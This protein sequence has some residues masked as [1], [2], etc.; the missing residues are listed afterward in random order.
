[1]RP[2]LV[3]SVWRV[4]QEG[5][6]IWWLTQVN[7]NT[8]TLKFSLNVLKLLWAFEVSCFSFCCLLIWI[9]ILFIAYFHS[10]LFYPLMERCE[11][12][13]F[14]ESYFTCL[15]IKGTVFVHVVVWVRSWWKCYTKFH[16]YTQCNYF[17]VLQKV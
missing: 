12:K 1:M 11:Q 3:I 2:I 4:R 15:Q 6:D 17:A 16:Q 7:D 5:H 8:D 10:S 14:V 9:K 13:V